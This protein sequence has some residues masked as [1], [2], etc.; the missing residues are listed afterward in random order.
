MRN[1]SSLFKTKIDIF[2]RQILSNNIMQDMP[3]NI[4][5]FAAWADDSLDVKKLSKSVIYESENSYLRSRLEGLL[6]LAKNCLLAKKND[7]IGD[8]SDL[9]KKLKTMG[10]LWAI[11]RDLHHQYRDQVKNLEASKKSLLDEVNRIKSQDK[12]IHLHRS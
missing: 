10:S 1:S 9:K 12:I 11:E 2:E 6:T 7:D 8:P 3:T 4:R 5:A